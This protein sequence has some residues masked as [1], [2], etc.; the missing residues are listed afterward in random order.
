MHISSKRLSRNLP[1]THSTQKFII[2]VPTKRADLIQNFRNSLKNRI[3][4]YLQFT[5]L[6]PTGC[7]DCFEV[8]SVVVFWLLLLW[9]KPKLLSYVQKRAEQACNRHKNEKNCKNRLRDCSRSHQEKV[10]IVQ[11]KQL[12]CQSFYLWNMVKWQKQILVAF[13]LHYIYNI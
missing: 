3:S 6:L 13:F 10:A 2:Y 8:I 12:K 9:K 4:H 1:D 5:R 11:Q 7:R